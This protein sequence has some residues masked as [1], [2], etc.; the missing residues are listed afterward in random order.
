VEPPVTLPRQLTRLERIAREL[1]ADA[2]KLRWW[3]RE[4][5]EWRQRDRAGQAGQQVAVAR[6]RGHV[7]VLLPVS[8]MLLRGPPR[9]LCDVGF[10]TGAIARMIVDQPS[11]AP[12]VL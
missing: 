1:D 3:L 2:D 8:E 7:G 11:K 5:V 6:Q 4:E 9:R 12:D 10:A